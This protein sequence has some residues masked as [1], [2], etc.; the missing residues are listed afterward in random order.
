M[1]IFL[2]L[3]IISIINIYNYLVYYLLS[4]DF[5]QFAVNRSN[6]TLI[7]IK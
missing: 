7:T 1:Y 5:V 4:P 3:L 6:F 2:N